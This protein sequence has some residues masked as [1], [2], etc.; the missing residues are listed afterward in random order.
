M[1]GPSSVK[2]H[3]LISPK[4]MKRKL[5]AL[6][7]LALCLNAVP[8]LSQQTD[9][10]DD[11]L[12]DQEQKAYDHA[13]DLAEETND[14]AAVSILRELYK[15]HPQN[16]NIA[17]NLGVC[18]VNMS[19]NPDSA[20]YFLRQVEAADPSENWSSD[21]LDLAMAMARAEQLCGNYDKALEI[22][23]QVK[24]HDRKGVWAD[25]VTKETKNS[26]AAIEFS[27]K[28]IKVTMRSVGDGINS[29]WNDYRPVL[30][31]N[32]DTIYFTSRRPNKDADKS[33][34]FKDGQ[35]EEGV[36]MS[37]RKGNRWDGGEWQEASAVRKLI[38]ATHGR[39][40]GQETV[41][42]LSADGSELYLCQDGDI[43]V[44]RR[45]SNSNKWLPAE[46]LPEPVNSPFNE[47]Y[48]YI[49]ADGQRL[50]ISSDAPGGFGGKDIYVSRRLPDG[51]WGTPLN[52]GA[53]VNST[54][55]E[56]APVFHDESNTLYFCSNG[57]AGMGGY[58]IYY[59]PET[60]QGTFEV[61]QNIGFPINS[62]DDDLFFFPSKDLG[63][64]Y[65]ASIRWNDTDKKPSYDI[66]EIE[67]EQPEMNTTAVLQAT[68][69]AKNMADVRI[70]TFINNELVGIS[71]PNQGMGSFVTVGPAGATFDIV[72]VCN[73]DTVRRSVTTNKS[74]AYHIRQL[75][76]ELQAFN[77]VSDAEAEAIATAREEAKA[78]HMAALRAQKD[79]QN[80]T[81]DAA[82]S[83]LASS[84][85]VGQMG[86]NGWVSSLNTEALP[87]TV[88]IMC[89]RKP[90]EAKLL[91]NLD[92]NQVAEHEYADGWF[93][94]SYGAFATYSQAK[95]EQMRIR[96]TTPY[97]TS[98]SRNSNQYQKYLK[99]SN[100]TTQSGD[101]KASPKK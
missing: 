100:S 67:F 29:E 40:S 4:S 32:E 7:L 74:D 96:E 87:Y 76:V 18:Y 63:R 80:G 6:T 71:R 23:D 25:V 3:A 19:G 5:I 36:Y 31:E 8:A 82:N 38:P 47:D 48:A 14:Q 28:P 75:P 39:Y 55:D 64:A 2:H 24:K 93:V 57:H 56:D 51:T 15:S 98:F 62:A 101:L 68:V 20:L 16:I 37:V 1:Y 78:E 92:P 72:A 97:R 13:I 60:E 70:S 12:N 69:F 26:N 22:Y 10:Q 84:N 66:Y 9:V 85:P 43:Y 42:S 73:G 91:R 33:V 89:L 59:A 46:R 11:K 88:Q 54:G 17:Y 41:T 90:L 30:S 45:D 58:D 79:A 53:A 34:I 27:L 94:Y 83:E 50:F 35:Y 44:A 99:K 86:A 81:A 95:K 61:V 49:T 21:R 77:F 52:L 65:Y